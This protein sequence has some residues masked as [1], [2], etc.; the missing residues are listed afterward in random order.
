MS[1]I[2]NIEIEDEILDELSEIENK[3]LAASIKEII[4][5]YIEMKIKHKND[6]IFNLGAPIKSG[7][8][9]VSKNHDKYIYNKR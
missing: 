1:K 3:D 5:K 7:F 2:I 8:S 6:P 4:K 9:D